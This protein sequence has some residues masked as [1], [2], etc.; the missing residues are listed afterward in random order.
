MKD[1][2]VYEQHEHLYML[3]SAAS[4]SFRRF[5]ARFMEIGVA[6]AR[7][8]AVMKRENLMRAIQ[9]A[10]S[11]FE[12]RHRY[13]MERDSLKRRSWNEQYYETYCSFGPGEG[14]PGVFA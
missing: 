4:R 7:A 8:Q 5:S 10:E 3:N 1:G 11:P 14:E 9:Q 6:T 2:Y 12:W 13:R